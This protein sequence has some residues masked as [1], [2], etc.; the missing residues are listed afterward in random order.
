M[1]TL[2][3]NQNPQ[4]TW[5]QWLSRFALG[6]PARTEKLSRYTPEIQN[7]LNQNI[8]ELLQ[9][10]GSNGLQRQTNKQLQ[11]EVIPN[12]ASRFLSS[13]N[14]NSGAFQAA[15][16]SAAA[17]TLQNNRLQELMSLLSAGAQDTNYFPSEPGVAQQI[18]P[19][20]VEL[21]KA[22]LNPVGTGLGWLNAL[23]EGQPQAQTPQS[24]APIGQSQPVQMGAASLPSQ[25]AVLQKIVDSLLFKNAPSSQQNTE[26]NLPQE[27]NPNAFRLGGSSL[28]P[29]QQSQSAM[30]LLRALIMKNNS[31]ASSFGSF[32]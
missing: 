19:A 22:Y 9:G 27:R 30:N 21:G 12:I 8:L 10:S 26:F 17:D 15:L 3:N 14:R 25:D 28:G 4:E 20:A 13:G 24:P 11:Q 23:M 5:G 6:N 31:G 7:E 32:Q 18:L 29:D 16:G 2:L 1:A